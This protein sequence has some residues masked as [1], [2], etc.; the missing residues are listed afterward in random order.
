MRTA[1]IKLVQQSL[2]TF[3]PPAPHLNIVL[4]RGLYGAGRE[5]YSYRC[6]KWSHG[7][8]AFPHWCRSR[9]DSSQRKGQVLTN[10]S[11]IVRFC[12]H[13]DCII[14]GETPIWVAT[15]TNPRNNIGD[16]I[17]EMLIEAGADVNARNAKVR[18]WRTC[19]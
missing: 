5:P 8:S 12:P 6:G 11:L 2:A 19:H 17:L 15:S 18:D 3:H 4:T 16:K 1:K 9:C 13:V 7:H 10:L 14:Q